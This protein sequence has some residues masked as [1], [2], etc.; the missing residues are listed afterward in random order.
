MSIQQKPA[1]QQDRIDTRLECDASSGPQNVGDSS[2]SRNPAN[3]AHLP[4]R[5]AMF[6]NIDLHATVGPKML[7]SGG[8]R[9]AMP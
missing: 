2:V 9:G 5:R 6:I 7:D 3:P 8:P 1:Q 4:Q